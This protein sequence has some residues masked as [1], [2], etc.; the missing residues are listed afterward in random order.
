MLS[1][2]RG[3]IVASL[4]PFHEDGSLDHDALKSHVDFMIDGGV[5]GFFCAGTYGEGPMLSPDDYR[6][7]SQ[8]F[9]EASAGRVPVIFQVSAPSTM[10]AVEQVR[11][12]T[13]AGVDVVAAVPAYYFKHDED[14]LVEYFETLSAATDKPVFIYDNPGRTGNP[15][16]VSLFKRLIENDRIVGMKDSSDSIVHFQKCLMEA[17]SD[18]KM[19]IGSDDFLVAGLVAGAQGAVVVLGN[20]FPRLLVDLWDAFTAGDVDR[21]IELQFEILRIRDVLKGG[22]YVSTYK[23]AVRLVGG[24]AGYARR[25]LRPLT[26]KEKAGLESGLRDLGVL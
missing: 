13:E 21:A 19:I 8:A 2:V 15:V 5:H 7:V 14:S 22:P 10:Q 11:I 1:K 25:P 24:N 18:F 9:V 26:D 6:E 23:E 12:V 4:T 16:T 3:V 20:V 17:G